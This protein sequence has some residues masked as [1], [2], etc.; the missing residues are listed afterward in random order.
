MT[1][2]RVGI[3]GLGVMGTQ[4]AES[5]ETAGHEV[6]ACADIDA[7]ARRTFAAEFDAEAYEDYAEMY[8][9]DIDAVIV[10]VPNALHADIAVAALEAGHDV[11]IEKPLA[12]SLESARRIRDAAR[13]ADGFCMVGFTLRFG[14]S[15]RRMRALTEEGYFGDPT[16]ATASYVRREGVPG[17]GRAWF[18]NPDL[19]G[20]GALVDIGVHVLDLALYA[21]DF[22]EVA[23][24]SAHAFNESADVDVEDSAVGFVRFEDGSTLV[25]EASW[26]ANTKSERAVSVRG[27]DGGACTDLGSVVAY[28]PDADGGRELDVEEGAAHE[29][30]IET[31]VESV[32]AGR[33]PEHCTVDEAFAVQQVMDAMYRSSEAGRAVEF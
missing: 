22:P 31:F 13:D 3:V 25:V 27:T 23:E 8:E 28:D 14:P 9:A 20:G 17:A 24:V 15:G 19:S 32:A 33:P 2:V 6:A 16:H 21:L 5:V 30:E 29:L 4:H 26:A 10:T 1:A 7:D 11:L 18:T 12:E